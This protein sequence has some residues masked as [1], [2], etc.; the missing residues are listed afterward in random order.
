MAMTDEQPAVRDVASGVRDLLR[1]TGASADSKWVRGL[2]A[3]REGNVL[4]AVALHAADRRAHGQTLTDLE[5]ALLGVVGTVLSDDELREAGAEYRATVATLGEVDLLPTRITG[6][7]QTKGFSFADLDAFIPVLEKESEHLA[8]VAVVDPADIA[9]GEAPDDAA[10]QEAVTD[11]GFG[12]TLLAGP[13]PAPGAS[14]SGDK[15]PTYR[16][17]LEF[18]RFVCE[19]EVGDGLSGRDEIYWTAATRSDLGTEKRLF[20]SEE[21][22]AVEKGDVRTFSSNNKVIFEG[23]AGEFVT[24]MITAWEADHS[25]SQWYDDLHTAM[26]AFLDY[27]GFLEL[28]PG[29]I[30]K[31]VEIVRSAIQLFVD[32]KEILRNKDDQSCMRGIVIDRAA[33]VS[34]YMRGTNTWSFDGDGKHILTIAY[35]GERP[36]FPVGTIEYATLMG[37]AG[38]PSW[39]LPV[40][41]GWESSS[42]PALAS[43]NGT[44]YSTYIRPDDNAV[45]WSALTDGTW[46]VPAQIRD[47]YSLFAPALCTHNGRVYAAI[48]DLD[49]YGE[50]C[51]LNNTGG[52]NSWGRCSPDPLAAPLAITSHND[53]LIVNTPPKKMSHAFFLTSHDDGLTW[54]SGGSLALY[55]TAGQPLSMASFGGAHMSAYRRADGTS[56]IVSRTG[57][58]AFEETEMWGWNMPDAPAITIHDSTLWMAMRHTNA[59]S[60]FAS[61]SISG[62]FATVEARL[63]AG[64][65][66]GAVALASHNDVLYVMYRR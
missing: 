49:G 29:K 19:R 48:T 14:R 25:N 45:M 34:L 46:T 7:E 17:R 58:W 16:V 54:A 60:I 27:T 5:Q 23:Q 26:Q 1:G 37:G 11:C 59:G 13:P 42:P 41:M 4:F 63:E 38:N 21:F 32:L 50:V 31:V 6:L 20:Q 30:G 28:I 40:A 33:L 22:G 18:D 12:T 36:K 66:G 65:M 52:W 2:R 53:E 51:S 15:W 55:P 43:L 8:N 39:S 35:T 61:R 10:F 44:L 47:Y 57:T 62:K 3:G 64:A 9:A 56:R 24:S